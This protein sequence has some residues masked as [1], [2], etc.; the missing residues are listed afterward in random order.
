MQCEGKTDILPAQVVRVCLSTLASIPCKLG[1]DLFYLFWTSWLGYE[2]LHAG[3]RALCSTGWN[4]P[5][6]LFWLKSLALSGATSQL[7]EDLFCFWSCRGK[8]PEYSL[9][10]FSHCM[11]IFVKY[12]TYVKPKLLLVRPSRTSYETRGNIHISTLPQIS[13]H[14]PVNVGAQTPGKAQIMCFNS[15]LKSYIC[16]G[17]F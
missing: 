10:R 5:N 16:W 14:K 2:E 9:L 6:F 17:F 7:V 3:V 12:I 1:T 13:P 4:F 8:N 11:G 15:S